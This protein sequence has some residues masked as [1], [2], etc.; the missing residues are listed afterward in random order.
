M[1]QLAQTFLQAPAP[2][3]S[4][5]DLVAKLQA[6]RDHLLS[7]VFERESEINGILLAIL[8]RTSCFFYGDVG[9]A[10]TFLIQS[11]AKLLGLSTFDI[12]LSETTKPDSIFGPVDIPA[13]ANGV[14]RTK[15]KGYAPD[16]EILFFDEIFKANA[17]VLNPLLWLINEHKYR[18]GD[19]GVI[20]CPVRATFSASNEIPDDDG[21]RAIYDRFL[22]RYEV[23]YIRNR[24]NLIKMVQSNLKPRVQHKV[25]PLTHVEIERL[26]AAVRDV[27]V[28]QHILETTFKIRDQLQATVGVTISDRRCA[29]AF[30]IMQAAALL[31]GRFEVQ[32]K[33]VEI[34]ANLFWDRPEQ[35]N[36]VTNIVL[37]SADNAIADLL[38]LSL[39]ADDIWDAAQKTGDITGAIKKL[40]SLY[41]RVCQQQSGRGKQIADSIRDKL[42]RANSVLQSRQSF[43]LI[44]M[45]LNAG[46]QYKVTS[47]TALL[48]SPKELRS[49]DMHF[50]RAGQ[51]WHHYGPGKKEDRKQYEK[52]LKA[53]IRENL[54]VAE[55]HIQKL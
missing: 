33:D 8:S 29:R 27:K 2:G 39:L 14:Q 13:L 4:L 51:Y 50:F 15:I 47:A 11:A 31:D 37:A 10:K 9:T 25:Q 32:P 7:V 55:V 22:L 1:T 20:D 6:I 21:S 30:R 41:S 28:E 43:S 49:V 38:S 24:S 12:L 5:T 36:R 26:T 16:S 52:K 3:T 40:E 48:W 44:R 46:I 23:S 42:D 45:R 18:N 53:K 54:G 19:D 34:L 35:I 17:T